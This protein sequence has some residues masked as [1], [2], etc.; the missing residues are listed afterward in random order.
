MQAAEIASL[1][2]RHIP[3]LA[4][5]YCLQLWEETPFLFKIRASRST[6]LG[7]FSCRP[8]RPPRITINADSPPFLFLIT[9]IHEVAHLR[10][11]NRFGWS[12]LPHGKEWKASFR[13]LCSPLFQLGVFPPPLAEA[14]ASHLH[15]PTA[16][17]LTDA[18]LTRALRQYDPRSAEALLLSDLP[19]GS[20]FQIRGRW[21]QKGELKRKRVLCRDLTNRRHYLISADLIIG[22]MGAQ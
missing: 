15:R 4:V 1:L 13:E 21:F 6:K 10:V 7:D 11:H 5:S 12:T 20:R 16:S 3:D 2:R 17:S 18:H 8:G 22:E 19:M 14:L 9:Y